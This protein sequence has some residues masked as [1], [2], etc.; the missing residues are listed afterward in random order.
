[1]F[2]RLAIVLCLVLVGA[3]GCGSAGPQMAPAKGKVLYKG[4]PLKFGGVLFQ[5]LKGE[6]AHGEIQPDGT[7]VL[8]THVEG[9]GA[10]VGPHL[11]SVTCYEGQSP[12]AI[13]SADSERQL[14]KLLIPEKYT[15]CES[16]GLK[17]EVKPQAQDNEFTLELK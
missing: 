15:N 7:F 9:D 1:M 6:V 13:G 3:T 17:A 11:V 4:Q 2:A 10:I 16:S 8:Y 5:P 14:G 12:N